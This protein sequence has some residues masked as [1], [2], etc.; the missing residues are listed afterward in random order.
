MM[1]A[2]ITAFAKSLTNL[3]QLPLP[4]LTRCNLLQCVCQRT[5]CLPSRK[6]TTAQ[7]RAFQCPIAVHT[8]SAKSGYFPG[9]IE[10]G[11]CIT[12]CIQHPAG[13][14]S[15]QAAQCFPAQDVQP[16]RNQRTVFAIKHF[17]WCCGPD[18]FVTKIIT[19]PV[20][21]AN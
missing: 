6:Q 18:Q 11:D 13:Q 4:A 19:R 9:S 15:L 7:K 8:A 12:L 3:I 5:A 10:T 14:I 20:Y 1:A 2:G 21:C 16:D 17:M